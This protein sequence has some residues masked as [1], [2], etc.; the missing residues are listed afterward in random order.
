MHYY[1]E[2]NTGEVI[3]QHYVPMTSNPDKL[4]PTRI[5]DV[6]KWIK[7]N[8][9]VVPSVTTVLGIINKHSLNTWKIN[10]HIQTCFDYLD[11]E[12]INM[13]PSLVEYISEIKRIT[14]LRL[15]EAPT[16]GTD[17]HKLM[18]SY[19]TEPEFQ[20]TDDERQLCAKVAKVLTD[21]CYNMNSQYFVEENFVCEEG[22]GGQIDLRVDDR[23]IIDYKTKQTKDKFKP[24]KMAYSDH[25]RQLAAYR[26]AKAPKAK[27]ANIFVCLENGEIDFHVHS[28][29][30]L[31]NGLIVFMNTLNIWENINYG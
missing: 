14:E 29:K 19:L 21:K 8:R 27:C 12:E 11:D 25:S 31:N 28:E 9:L 18:Q 5:T 2:L 16:A 10:Q 22:Y 26:Y 30:D 17:F 3:P 20:G 1:E 24:G 6:R 13:I 15:E 4:R 23:W 7:E